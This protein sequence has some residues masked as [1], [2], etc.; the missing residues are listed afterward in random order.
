[1]AELERAM[2]RTGRPVADGVTLAALEQRFSASGHAVGYVRAVRLARY[3]GG[4]SG[5]TKEE[6][7]ALRRQLAAG[8]GLLGR[9]RALWALPPHLP[10]MPSN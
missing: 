9:L 3:G 4:D 2:R 6:R 7:R 10:G 5:P 8:L 1:V